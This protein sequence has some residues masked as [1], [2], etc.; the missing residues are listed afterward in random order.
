MLGF[1]EALN[2]VLAQAKILGTQKII[3]ENALG[4]VLSQP[5]IAQM[6]QPPFDGSSMDGY[7][8]S[9]VDLEKCL[10][11]TRVGESQAGAGFLSNVQPGQCA[12]I[13]TGAPLP[14]GTDTVIM[15]E[16]ARVKGDK[17]TFEK[18][19][20]MGK[21]VRPTGQDFQYGDE[22]VK[23]GT[24]L[25]PSA[26]ALIAAGNVP[27]IEVYKRPSIGLMA[28]GDE[29]MP[30]GSDLQPGQIIG[31]NSFALTALFAPHCEQVFNLG[32]APDQEHLLREKFEE[33]L[34][35][36]TDIIVS[37]GGASVGDH[38]LVLPVLKSLG[39]EIDFWKIAMR[40]GK[41][42]MFARHNDKLIF[43]LPGNPVSSYVGATTFVLP[44]I[45]AISGQLEPQAKTLL[46]P[47]ASPLP[48]NGARRYFMRCEIKTIEGRT[49]AAPILQHDSSH[50]SS[51]VK[52]DGLMIVHENSEDMQAGDMI[53]VIPV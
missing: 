18:T 43:A 17:I 20:P 10:T 32:N 49:C 4:R 26:I 52:A 29:L 15:Q 38:D 37:T 33:A 30:P 51:L 23:A 16:M 5:V 13:F 53:E 7:A 21:N 27:E 34:A 28:T 22:L 8:L 48:A 40:P 44:A 39:V 41:P 2:R 6:T 14:T 19:V 31:S 42:I 1:N 11:F 25:N 36:P 46:L 47:L 35:G 24:L 9:A 45:R 12:R 3:L 50:L